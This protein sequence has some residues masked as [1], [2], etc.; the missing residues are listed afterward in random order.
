MAEYLL[1][2]G[3]GVAEPR[4]HSP[5]EFQEAVGRFVEWSQRLHAEGHFVSGDKLCSDGRF[6]VRR[7]GAEVVV[8]GPYAET[9][10]GVAGY[11]K[12]RADSLDQALDLARTC[13]LL[14]QGGEVIVMEVDESM[15]P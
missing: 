3:N 6:A 7:R 10:E 4:E 15:K 14:W 8:D 11:Y 9:K 2:L 12:V 13:P 5:E 1:L